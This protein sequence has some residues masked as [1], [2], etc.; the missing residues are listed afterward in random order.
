MKRLWLCAVIACGKHEQPS[1]ETKAPPPPPVAIDASREPVGPR[2]EWSL[3]VVSAHLR[4]PF[5]A[6][7][8]DHALVVQ[9]DEGVRLVRGGKVAW[10]VS[11]PTTNNVLV[12]NAM[13]GKR[14]GGTL[15]LLDLS[16]R[17]LQNVIV[18]NGVAAFNAAGDTVIVETA[19]NDLFEIDPATCTK[20]SCAKRV[21][22]L[23]AD[24]IVSETVGV[25]RDNIW[26]ATPNQLQVSD[27]H[28]KVKLDL[29]F[30][31]DNHEV[32]VAG[33]QV[34]IDDT[35]G[36]AILSL[37]G[38]I[39]K[40]TTWEIGSTRD[41]LP[42]CIVAHQPASVDATITP[43]AIP[44]G[45][46]AYNDHD[47]HT[48]LFGGVASWTMDL[49]GSGPVAGDADFVYIVTLGLDDKGPVRVLALARATGHVAWQTDLV[50]TPPPSPKITIALRDHQLVVGLGPKLYALTTR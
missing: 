44:R 50:A 26:A 45:A 3:D 7:T 38:C 22:A 36:V 40:K 17:G 31:N 8:A 27:R 30:S 12:G 10:T 1:V 35:H 48:V 21:G 29:A 2:V 25:W 16:S 13:V 15:G 24:S 19:A 46:V 33:D 39:A 43:T 49:N 42:G 32:I 34:L 9:D 18:G 20:P 41:D 28:G 6:W 5:L 4:E 23:G 37:P 47:G 14:E 11:D